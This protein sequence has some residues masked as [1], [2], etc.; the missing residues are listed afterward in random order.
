VSFPDEALSCDGFLDNKL[1]VQQ[2]KTGY[3]AATD[4]VF[5]A[6]S[7]PAI[8]GQ[9]VL[10]LGCGAGVASLC[11]GYRVAGVDLAAVEIQP[12]YAELARQNAGLN[13]QDLRVSTAD[14]SDLPIELRQS[15][16]DH[17]IAN[18]PYL[19]ARSGTPAKDSGK[20]AAFREETALNE[21]IDVA[22]KRLKPRG[23][24]TLIHLSERLPE[25]LGYLAGRVGDI[26][27]KPIASRQSQVATRVVIRARKGARGAFRLYPPFVVHE[28]DRHVEDRN[29]F[30]LRAR[31]I[32]R[33]GLP[34]TF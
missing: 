1:S 30:T 28:G 31:E 11:L 6:A 22:I 33:D 34:L 17:V 20:E 26:E 18:P 32:L 3:R 25:I 5:L 13:G 29:D 15:S 27:V 23:F 8:A 7:V 24:L 16:F 10:E 9:S 4:P 21:W 12:E 2:P 19:S 14:I